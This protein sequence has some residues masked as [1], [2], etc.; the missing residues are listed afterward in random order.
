[1]QEEKKKKKKKEGEEGRGVVN[2]Y[3]TTYE[4]K[5]NMVRGVLSITVK[6]C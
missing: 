3:H 4:W 6:G 2:Q 1:M 5:E